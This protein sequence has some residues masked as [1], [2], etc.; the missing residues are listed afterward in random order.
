ME[1]LY[2]KQCNMINVGAMMP[3]MNYTPQTAEEIVTGCMEYRKLFFKQRW[4]VTED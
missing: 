2:D 4:E 3:Y 1:E